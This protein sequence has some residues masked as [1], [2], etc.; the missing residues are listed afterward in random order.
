MTR[1]GDML[2]QSPADIAAIKCRTAPVAGRPA[3]RAAASSRKT[4]TGG[5]TDTL[6]FDFTYNPFN[7]PCEQFSWAEC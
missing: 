7:V 1:M 5:N 4:W 3:G 6:I 2:S